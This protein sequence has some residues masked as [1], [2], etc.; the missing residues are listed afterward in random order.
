M[1]SLI[2]KCEDLKHITPGSHL[3]NVLIGIE[4]AGSN[5][6]SVVSPRIQV[7]DDASVGWSLVD[8]SELLYPSDLYTDPILEEVHEAL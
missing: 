3:G 7:C 2:V 8:L 5:S 4:K 1:D 6:Y